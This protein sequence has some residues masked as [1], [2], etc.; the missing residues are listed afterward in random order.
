MPTTKLFGYKLQTKVLKLSF[1]LV[2]LYTILS[3]QHY[4]NKCEMFEKISIKKTSTNRR[5]PIPKKK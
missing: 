1:S 5:S 3:N 2:T 4:H